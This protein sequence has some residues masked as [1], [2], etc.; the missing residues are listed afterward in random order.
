MQPLKAQ[1]LFDLESR[2]LILGKT[3]CGK[4]FLGRKIQEKY[5]RIVIIDS[6]GEYKKDAGAILAPD[7]QSFIRELSR[8][9]IEKRPA[10]KL[11]FTFPLGSDHDRRLAEMNTIC[12]LVFKFKGL[13][14]VVEEAQ[15]FCSPQYMPSWFED[16]MTLGRHNKIAVL[17]TTQKPS[18][19]RKVIPDMCDH[20]FIGTIQGVNDRQYCADFL[21]I[22]YNDFEV[23]PARVFAHYYNGEIKSITANEI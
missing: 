1:K 12:E 19:I 9:Y 2:I 5:P 8:L 21:G 16:L 7:L 17:M 20:V 3:K 18:L 22:K 15:K 23:K 13:L 11:V 6:L 14:L 4:S 10:F